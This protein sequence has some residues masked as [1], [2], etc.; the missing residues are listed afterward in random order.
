MS[1]SASPA[2]AQ[3]AAAAFNSCTYESARERLEFLRCVYEDFCTRQKPC[4]SFVAR[5]G[6]PRGNESSYVSCCQVVYTVGRLKILSGVRRNIMSC[7]LS[8]ILLSQSESRALI[9]T[10]FP[11]YLNKLSLLLGLMLKIVSK[12]KVTRHPNKPFTYSVGLQQICCVQ[13]MCK[14]VICD[15]FC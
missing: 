7:S 11:F 8:N 4:T 9:I 10:H 6:L 14:T 5:C 1:P 2:S 13:K 15:H 12:R 3:K